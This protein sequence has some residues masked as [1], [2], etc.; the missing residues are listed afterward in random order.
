MAPPPPELQ[1]A[2]RQI[3]HPSLRQ[4]QTGSPPY[5]LEQLLNLFA[6][7]R[8][9][10]SGEVA[11]SKR[12]HILIAVWVT[13]MSYVIDRIEQEALRVELGIST[14]PGWAAF[15]QQIIEFW[16][17]FWL[18]V[19]LTGC[20][21]GLLVWLVGGWWFRLRLRWAGAE[22][23]NPH[24]SRLV[25]IYASL[26]FALP[27]LFVALLWTGV[28]ARYTTA[29]SEDIFLSLLVLIFA[30]WELY[31]AYVGVRTWFTLDRRKAQLWFAIL[32]G[33][34]YIFTYLAGML[35]LRSVGR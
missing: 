2:D 31:S 14:L 8:Y 16:P 3:S 29:Y 7:P 28:Q 21:A 15:R 17:W 4:L 25:F 9:F 34:L 18:F 27:N 33:L 32:P 13:G 19:A 12:R 1:S 5:S 10:F 26:V 23:P 6:H 24:L 20:L 11:L 35:L 30:Y 22:N